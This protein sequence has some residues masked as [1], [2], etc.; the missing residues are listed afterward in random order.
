[1][2]RSIDLLNRNSLTGSTQNISRHYDLG[3]KFFSVF[4]D[5]LMMYSSPIYSN[6]TSS[7]GEA[8]EH[9]LRV[10]CAK[11]ELQAE[12]HLLEIGSGWGGMAIYAAKNYGCRVTTTTIS[13][14]QYSR[15]VKESVML[16]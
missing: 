11:L 8:A 6:E 1:M 13:K 5:P 3:N 15:L 10:V 14:G 2:T 16:A 12:D 7:L 9:K 4:L